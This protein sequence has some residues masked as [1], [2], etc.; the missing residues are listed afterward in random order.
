M[1]LEN[2]R[3]KHAKLKLARLV[4]LPPNTE[5]LVNCRAD[6]GTKYLGMPH[7]L[8]QP[9][10]NSWCYADDSIV[11]GLSLLARDSETHCILVT[12]LFDTRRILNQGA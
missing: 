6:Q 3:V 10:G 9:S 7:M 2:A 12:N 5:V 4:E 11:I 8:A 1:Y